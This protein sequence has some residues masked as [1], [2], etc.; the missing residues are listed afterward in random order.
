MFYK[1]YIKLYSQNNINK[2]MY[3]ITKLFTK[4]FSMTIDKIF[5]HFNDYTE[6]EVITTLKNM[7]DE[8]VVI[9]NRYGFSSYLRES[10]NIYF[11]INSLFE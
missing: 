2:I 10:N 6:F 4:K 7:I 1:D 11:L 5:E 3:E 8:S 9:K